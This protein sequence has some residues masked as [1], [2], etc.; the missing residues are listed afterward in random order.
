MKLLLNKHT[1]ESHLSFATVY[2]GDHGANALPSC[3]HVGDHG[4]YVSLSGDK[5]YH[6]YY[7]AAPILGVIMELTNYLAAPMLVIM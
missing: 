1:W 2:F 6:V 7:L 4:A 3:S 5:D